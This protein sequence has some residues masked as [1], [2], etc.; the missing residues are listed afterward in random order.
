MRALL[1]SVVGVT[2]VACAASARIAANR[3][4]PGWSDSWTILEES[5]SIAKDLLQLAVDE[6]GMPR[7]LGPR[8]WL[9]HT[10]G[11][12]MLCR[13]NTHGGGKWRFRLSGERWELIDRESWVIVS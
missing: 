3:C 13:V 9:S 4:E 2:L 10:D 6:P 8:V 11:S 5:P 1:L 12:I 7:A